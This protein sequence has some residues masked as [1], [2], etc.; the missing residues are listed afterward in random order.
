[1]RNERR[2]HGAQRLIYAKGRFK[3]ECMSS[4][5]RFLLNY[6]NKSVQSS[7]SYVHCCTLMQYQAMVI[8][9]SPTVK[10]KMCANQMYF[11]LLMFS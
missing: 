4:S 11:Q 9:S 1:M 8:A 5:C 6:K 10:N 7:V 2:D 3:T